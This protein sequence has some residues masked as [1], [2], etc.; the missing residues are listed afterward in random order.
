MDFTRCPV[1][2]TLGITAWHVC[3]PKWRGR[4]VGEELEDATDFYELDA[5]SAACA[6]AAHVNLYSGVYEHERQVIIT[7]ADGVDQAFD[8]TMALVPEYYARPART[9]PEGSTP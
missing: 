8:V 5:R 4:L 9:R 7:G 1:C 3:P 2:K 6:A